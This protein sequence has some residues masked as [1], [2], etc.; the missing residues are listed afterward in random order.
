MF[1]PK[2]SVIK[3]LFLILTFSL[4][5]GLA[6]CA[7]KGPT[8]GRTQSPDAPAL[9]AQARDLYGKAY[10][11]ADVKAAVAAYEKAIRAGSPEAACDLAQLYLSGYA[12]VTPG[13]DETAQQAADKAAFRLF[14]QAAKAG[15]ALAQYQTAI[16]YA[17]ARGVDRNMAEARAWLLKA[18]E[19]DNADAQGKLGESYNSDCGCGPDC[20]C[21]A[22]CCFGL[23][24]DY[25]KSVYWYE[26]LA[27]NSDKNA[28]ARGRSELASLYEQGNDKG[29]D[30]A[31]AAKLYEDAARQGDANAQ[32]ELA[33][34]Y[35]RGRG[36]PHDYEK[37]VTMHEDLLER[38]GEEA[39]GYNM[40]VL[41]YYA[42][43][44]PDQ[45]WRQKEA[46]RLFKNAA[47]S[48]DYAY[49]LSALGECY[50]NGVGVTRNYA[51]AAKYYGLAA[52]KDFAD[53]QFLLGELY[54]KGLGVKRDYKE[55]LRLFK[56]ASEHDLA[57]GHRGVAG[58]YYRGEGVTRDH[59]HALDM[60][61]KAA[62]GGDQESMFMLGQMYER[63]EGTGKDPI[64]ARKWYRQAAD[65]PAS[66]SHYWDPDTVAK[67]NAKAR[68]ALN[69]LGG[70]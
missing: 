48:G 15:Y 12:P 10:G 54:R 5:L 41:Y 18:G 32:S 44:G 52:D 42:P 8:L 14:L 36:V 30:Y 1:T 40:A 37:A 65:Y 2:T 31:Q 6:G 4:A 25:A 16:L 56:T 27:A 58:A 9:H 57:W 33:F 46:F 69:R 19:A 67:Y 22:A 55:A 68:E 51:E 64:A 11:E 35:F 34:M 17:E 38:Y 7:G 26:R 28:A 66:E 43:A 47:D 29:P 59:A 24:R 53:A 45:A 61:T 13:K 63:G 49:A 21:G 70:E 20:D 60:Y 23:P 39:Y 3:H 62:Q 50:E